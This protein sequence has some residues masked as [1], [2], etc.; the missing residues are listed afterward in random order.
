[1]QKRENTTLPFLQKQLDDTKKRIANLISSIE[2]DIASD[3]IKQ[4]L[5]ELETSKADLEISI[6]QEKIEKTPLTKE[7]FVFWISKFK[8]GDVD[9]P[10][11][12]KSIVDIFVNSIFLYEDKLVIAFNWKDGAKTVTLAELEEAVTESK[13]A[14]HVEDSLYTGTFWGSFLEQFPAPVRVVIRASAP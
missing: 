7:Q 5:D 1:M 6:A 9:D 2:E 8:G 10:A 12:R 4:R 11:Y 3:S 13:P 14:D